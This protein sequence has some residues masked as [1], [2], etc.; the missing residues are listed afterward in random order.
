[1]AG[2]VREWTVN[3]H[4]KGNNRF[5]ILGGAYYD[6]VYN[7]NDYYSTFPLDRSLGNGCRLVSSLANGVEDSLDQYIISYTER[8]ILSEED[9]T[10]E[11]FEVYRAQFDYKD[12]PLEVDLT[13][14][15]EYDSEYVVER[16]EMETPYKNDEPL[17][18]FIV[19]DSSYKGDLKPIIQFPSAGAIYTNSDERI[20]SNAIRGKNYLLKE[21]YAVI[22]P[23][24]YSTYNRRKTLRTWWAN[25]T[26]EYKESIIKIGK[27]YRRCIDYIES[28]DDFDFQNLSYVGFSWGSIMSN[29][30]LAIDDRVKIAFV[31]VGGLQ[32]P[33]CK[34]EIDPSLFIRRIKI[35]VMHI[36]GRLD[37]IFEYENSQ[38]P[39]QKLLGTPKKD[40]KMI[41]L[42]GV[43]HGIP[44][45]TVV[46]NHL[47]WLRKYETD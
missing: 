7:F 26:E 24:Y 16:F 47:E 28:R 42:D 6:N 41:V 35:P 44:K 14:I 32:V 39:M 34:R 46:V 43:G 1:M 33:K 12:Y 30:L 3:P 10:D 38:I 27:D 20:A 37:G 15:A 11:V 19:Y 40:Q 17:H 13:I 31:C 36:T 8:D 9:V 22:H 29:T 45:D 21:G 2:N 4:G 25:E 5:S 18:G 23:V